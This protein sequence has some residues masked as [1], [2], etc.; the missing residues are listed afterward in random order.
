MSNVVAQAGQSK[1]ESPAS[2]KLT[3]GAEEL[4]LQVFSLQDAPSSQA[5]KALAAKAEC[6]EEQVRAFFARQRSAVRS[7]LQ[8]AQRKAGVT[9]GTPALQPHPSKPATV[10]ASTS[11][12]AIA[13]V[14][15]PLLQQLAP[16]G[17]AAFAGNVTGSSVDG[18]SQNADGAEAPSSP[19]AAVRRAAVGRDAALRRLGLL[20]D[21]GGGLRDSSVTGHFTQLMAQAQVPTVRC[22]MLH[23]LLATKRG[24]ARAKLVHHGGFL[25]LLEQWLREAEE[26]HQTTL[27]LLLLQVLEG[28][29]L[30]P[31]ALRSTAFLPRAAARLQKPG[32][33]PRLTAA[34]QRL[35]QQWQQGAAQQGPGSGGGA[36][37][38]TAAVEAAVAGGIAATA[39]AAAGSSAPG[40]PAGAAAAAAQAALQ[41]HTGTAAAA[42]M[43]DGGGDVPGAQLDSLRKPSAVEVPHLVAL[44]R[45][46]LFGRTGTA[47]LPA[48][49]GRSISLDAE[50]SGTPYA[51]GTPRGGGLRRLLS[52]GEA[53][54]T[55]GAAAASPRGVG[56]GPG[57]GQPLRSM[58]SGGAART[59]RPLSVDDIRKQK[60]RQ[61]ASAA[62]HSLGA[63]GSGGTGN[64]ALPAAKRLRQEGHP[65]NAGVPPSQPQQVQLAQQT[66]QQQATRLPFGAAAAAAAPASPAGLAAQSS[67]PW[68]GP[69]AAQPATVQGAEMAQAVERYE[70]DRQRRAAVR[71]VQLVQEYAA[72]DAAFSRLRAMRPSLPAYPPPPPLQ[73]PPL[74][75]PLGQGEDSSE[76]PA[77][78][79]RQA[80]VP[81]AAHPSP[82]ATLPSPAEPPSEG[83]VNDR[84]TPLV[85][86]YP[87]DPQERQAQNERLLQDGVRLPQ[88]VSLQ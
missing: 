57:A 41:V 37:E 51:A 66:Q 87:L 26:D 19:L 39:G 82:A 45:K 36:S 27:L 20:L 17:T 32:R 69:G 18:G 75:F 14:G 67:A 23:V 16:A 46:S 38:A 29:P 54:G 56:T 55:T 2:S 47:P 31:A 7:F 15:K 12:T 42:A 85:P 24:G 1:R 9:A 53:A 13:S 80:Q 21:E 11:P 44:G 68:V 40:G 88:Y 76:A 81:R 86:F 70:Q 50:G 33:H 63:G 8:R 79:T 84:V 61:R 58:L 4:F 64:A 35:A 28:T 62:L 49:V 30:P 43:T 74:D 73:L 3:A 65:A 5:V 60:E 78:R 52:D 71:K 48:Q 25:P 34:A 10:A 22:A 59:A 72:R 83:A 6:E 77:Q